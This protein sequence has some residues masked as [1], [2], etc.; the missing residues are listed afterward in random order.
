MD[1]WIGGE[2]LYAL[3]GEFYE[4][5]PTYDFWRYNITSNSWTAMVDVPAYPHDGGVG[6][7]G[8][9]GSLLHIGLWLSNQTDFIYALSGNQAHPESPS[10]IPDNRFYRYTIS[11]ESWERLADLPFGIGYYV[12]C[13]LGYA[14]GHIYAW[15]GTPSTWAG[16]GD[17]LAY[18]EFPIPVGGIYIPANKL[19]LL[20]PYI[21]LTILLAVAVVTVV[22]VK[23]RKRNTKINS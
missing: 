9:G 12:G 17:D 4:D 3:R 11:T 19:E 6:G 7:V 14:E 1:V 21:G 22:Y 20:A 8:D 23:K 5:S 16:G 10:P 15:Q 13:R 18:Y 2:L